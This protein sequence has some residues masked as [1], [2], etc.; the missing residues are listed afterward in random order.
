MSITQFSTQ[1][2]LPVQGVYGYYTAIVIKSEI[3]EAVEQVRKGKVMGNLFHIGVVFRHKNSKVLWEVVEVQKE[4]DHVKLA[5]VKSQKSGYR[6]AIWASGYSYDTFDLVSAPEAVKVLYG[7]LKHIR[8]AAQEVSRVI[9]KEPEATE[10]AF[11]EIEISETDLG[12]DK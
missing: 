2:I 6:K 3:F 7:D 12:N 11:E 1:F 5:I 9:L 8:T 10:V 4:D